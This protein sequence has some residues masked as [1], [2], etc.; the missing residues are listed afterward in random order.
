MNSL[1]DAVVHAVTYLNCTPGTGMEDEEIAILDTLRGILEG[2]TEAEKDA[3]AEAADRAFQAEVNGAHRMEFMRDYVYWMQDMFGAEEWRGNDRKIF[4][5]VGKTCEF[6]GQEAACCN[7]RVPQTIYWCKDCG[8]EFGRMFTEL[9][10]ADRP[11]L[12]KRGREE[13][14]FLA[15]RL[16]P[17][18][19]AWAEAAEKKTVQVMKERRQRAEQRP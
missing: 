19:R 16:D 18:L 17:E 9:C 3:L 6:C 5:V 7:M 13:L 14:S 12:R 8:P 1:A 11:E 15:F 4:S 10:L 2:C